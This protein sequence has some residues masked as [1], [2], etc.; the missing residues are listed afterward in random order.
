MSRFLVILK[1]EFKKTFSKSMFLLSLVLLAISAFFLAIKIKDSP[2]TA[3][4]DAVWMSELQDKIDNIDYYISTHPNVD[5]GLLD[6][7][8]AEREIAAYQI[9]NNIQPYSDHSTVNLLLSINTLYIL[10]VAVSLVV[11]TKII[12]DEH[13]NENLKFLFSTPNSRWKFLLGKFVVVCVTPFI[14]LLLMIVIAYFIGVLIFGGID[15]TTNYLEYIN[16]NIVETPIVLYIIKSFMY[17]IYSIIVLSSLAM[18]IGLLLRNPIYSL[19]TSLVIYFVSISI[20]GAFIRVEW[21]KYTIFPHINRQTLINESV[22]NGDISVMFSL[23]MMTFY[24]A[25]FVSIS[26]WSIAQRDV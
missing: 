10:I 8:I 3:P 5:P 12:S 26:F 17:N 22:L 11:A 2:D 25:L 21:F 16:G 14:Y 7:Y 15:T 6:T 24:L 1:Y 13:K 9:A 23:M 20:T 19:V 4:R 18:M